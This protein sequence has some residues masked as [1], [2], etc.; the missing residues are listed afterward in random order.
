MRTDKFEMIGIPSAKSCVSVFLQ[1]VQRN[2]YNTYLTVS[3]P[4]Y[5][6][7]EYTRPKYIYSLPIEKKKRRLHT[8]Y[9][10][11]MIKNRFKLF[12]T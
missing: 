1:W 4:T 6:C 11:V 7:I 10:F 2:I 3:V 8:M 5:L 9:F 12:Y